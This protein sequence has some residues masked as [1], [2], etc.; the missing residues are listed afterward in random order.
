MPFRQIYSHNGASPRMWGLAPKF[1]NVLTA[2]QSRRRTSGGKA[3]TNNSSFLC[4]VGRAE[5]TQSRI[6]GHG[7][8]N[9]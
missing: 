5:A 3:A 7:N 6:P 2:G 4:G 8:F 9:G 1:R